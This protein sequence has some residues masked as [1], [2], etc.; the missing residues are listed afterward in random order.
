MSFMALGDQG[1]LRS[2]MTS[3]PNVLWNSG[4]ERNEDCCHTGMKGMSDKRR[5]TGKKKQWSLERVHVHFFPGCLAAVS[6]GE[7]PP[8]L[9]TTAH[10]IVTEHFATRSSKSDTR[11]PPDRAIP[12]LCFSLNCVD[13]PGY[14]DS[15]NRPTVS[16]QAVSG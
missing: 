9:S 16:P 6:R 11:R 13:N 10:L 4:N 15:S 2:K 3:G 8:A 1:I 12:K 14:L 5:M 7:Q